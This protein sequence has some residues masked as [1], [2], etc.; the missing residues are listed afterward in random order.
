MPNAVRT[1][2][3]W[4]WANAVASMA[5][6]RLK[7]ALLLCTSEGMEEP[8]TSEPYASRSKSS[9]APAENLLVSQLANPQIRCGRR[10]C[11]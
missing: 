8:M 9:L 2:R 3:A 7:T 5:P 1:P 10:V 11:A 6:T 4:A